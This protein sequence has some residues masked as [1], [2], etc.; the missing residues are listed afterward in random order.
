[1]SSIQFS[2]TSVDVSLPTLWDTMLDT[3]IHPEKYLPEITNCEI[4]KRTPTEIIRSI[5]TKFGEFIERI[6]IDFKNLE[7]SFNLLDHPD[8]TGTL[9][10]RIIPPLKRGGFALLTLSREWHPKRTGVEVPFANLQKI[11]QKTKQEAEKS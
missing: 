11:A 6:I 4:I 8:F 2:S 10:S 1:M 7:I 9:K 5:K 3:I